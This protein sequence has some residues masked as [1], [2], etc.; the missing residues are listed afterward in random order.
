MYDL[1]CDT[2]IVENELKNF[3]YLALKGNYVSLAYL[4]KI[5]KINLLIKSKVNIISS[6]F[7][8]CKVI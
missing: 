1:I 6:H 8:T 3:I 5:G 4:T 7:N 2:T